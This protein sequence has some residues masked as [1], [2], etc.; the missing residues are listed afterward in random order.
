MGFQYI[1]PEAQNCPLGERSRRHGNA[2]QQHSIELQRCHEHASRMPSITIGRPSLP[3]GHEAYGSLWDQLKYIHS[4]RRNKSIAK[5]CKTTVKKQRS[6]SPP[7]R[8]DHS[9]R[10]GETLYEIVPP[11]FEPW[12]KTDS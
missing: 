4:S 6:P 12:N 7:Y 5:A 11:I 1:H 8:L 10:D 2:K 9:V 3:R